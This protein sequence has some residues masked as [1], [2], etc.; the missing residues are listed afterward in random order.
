MAWSDSLA[1][2]GGICNL[3]GAATAVLQMAGLPAG[4]WMRFLL[5]FVVG[6]AVYFLYSRRRLAVCPP[7]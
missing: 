3:L 1:G 4:T 2:G 6:L 7:Q 5:W